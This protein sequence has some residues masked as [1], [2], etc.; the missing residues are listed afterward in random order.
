MVQ[1]VKNPAI[2]IADLRKKGS[3]RLF[4]AE[5]SYRR[6]DFEST[7]LAFDKVRELQ[8][9]GPA[10][11]QVGLAGWFFELGNPWRYGWCYHVPPTS[12]TCSRLKQQ[13]WSLWQMNLM[14]YAT[15]CRCRWGGGW[16]VPAGTQPALRLSPAAA[17]YPLQSA[18][19]D[20]GSNMKQ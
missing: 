4:L 7:F 13:K 6:G 17:R 3:A 20:S 9:E 2:A 5:T 1:L 14:L 8:P 16:S 11:E 19:F 18:V 12:R 15:S 10:A